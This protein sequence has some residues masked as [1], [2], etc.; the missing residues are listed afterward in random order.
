MSKYEPLHHYLRND[1]RERVP[2]TF[3]EVE[4]VLGFALPPSSRKDRE[5]WSD[6]PDR[7]VMAQA[8]LEAGYVTEAVDMAFESVVFRRSLDFGDLALQRPGRAT[9]HK[10]R[11]ERRHPLFGRLKGLVSV[12]EGADLTEPADPDWGKLA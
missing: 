10:P 6:D 2:L 5:W 7:N 8:W 9:K 3:N 11:E 1:G 12:A 4:R